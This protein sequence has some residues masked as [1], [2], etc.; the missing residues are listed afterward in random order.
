MRLKNMKVRKM[1]LKKYEGE[2]DG[3]STWKVA[4]HNLSEIWASLGCPARHHPPEPAAQQAR[5][6]PLVSY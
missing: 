2:K 5:H 4:F 6:H 1:R 3:E